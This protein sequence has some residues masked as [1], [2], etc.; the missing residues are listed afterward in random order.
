MPGLDKSDTRQAAVRAAL[1]SCQAE[2]GLFRPITLDDVIEFKP[3]RLKG[4]FLREGWS[5]VE[6]DGVW[7]LGKRATLDI[8]CPQ[9]VGVEVVVAIAFRAFVTAE[10]SQ[11]V[12]ISAGGQRLRV[13]QISAGDHR[14]HV[15]YQSAPVRNGRVSLELCLPRACSPQS[16]FVGDD[17]RELAIK[18]ISLQALASSNDCVVEAVPDVVYHGASVFSSAPVQVSHALE[19]PLPEAHEGMYRREDDRDAVD[20]DLSEAVGSGFGALGF[21][22]EEAGGR[23]TRSHDARLV[24]PLDGLASSSGKLDVYFS[25]RPYAP[26]ARGQSIIISVMNRSARYKFSQGDG[27]RYLVCL[28]GVKRAGSETLKILVRTETLTSPHSLA[29]EGDPRM[30]GVQVSRVRVQSARHGLPSWSR[31]HKLAR[32]RPSIM[33]SVRAKW[34]R[35]LYRSSDKIGDTVSSIIEHFDR[36]L[37]D[38]SG[39]IEQLGE[40]SSLTRQELSASI[41][42][43]R[44][45][46]LHLHEDLYSRVNADVSV[47]IKDAT[48]IQ[49]DVRTLHELVGVIDARQQSARLALESLSDEVRELSAYASIDLQRVMISAVSKLFEEAKSINSQALEASSDKIIKDLSGYGKQA[50]STLLSESHLKQEA[51]LNSLRDNI[52]AGFSDHSRSAV[53]HLFDESQVRN[54]EALKGVLERIL[55]EVPAHTSRSV[56]ALLEDARGRQNESLKDLSEEIQKAIALHGERQVQR[57]DLAQAVAG[58]LRAELDDIQ[59]YEAQIQALVEGL[60]SK[61]DTAVR[62]HSIRYNEDT[63]AIR[64]DY[65]YVLVPSNDLPLILHILFTPSHGYEWGTSQVMKTVV[66]EGMNVADVGA[67][68]GMHTLLLA[69]LVGEDGKVHAVEP[70]A[71]LAA[72]LRLAMALNGFYR[73]ASVINIAAGDAAG[74]ALLNRGLTSSHSSF[75]PLD[76]ALR[77]GSE[78]VEIATLDDAI[79]ERLD[80]LKI[81]A[82]GYELNILQGA[83]RH[84]SNPDIVVVA[85]FANSHV[86]RAGGKS[87]AWF[88]AMHQRG[89]SCFLIAAEPTENVLSPLADVAFFEDGNYLMVRRGSRHWSS[90]ISLSSAALQ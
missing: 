80:F 78:M 12:E 16:L 58:Q 77:A 42:E 81:D 9:G 38:L 19:R 49:G 37:L 70:L 39:R 73:R 61:V 48:K 66:A 47:A 21:W 30:I 82:E 71:D 34:D 90:L 45:N 20:L 87:E 56:S 22:A 41:D 44:K 29:G 75:F 23:W 79:P 54:E 51:S 26:L 35:G 33:H 43:V 1:T 18:L 88:A 27:N 5:D 46:S 65:G 69:R 55:V 4:I 84:L 72:N 10:H 60:H 64:T 24:V 68:V 32:V 8:L 31:H 52:M 62:R 67:N 28:P 83:S 50:I 13:V 74:Q 6:P 11:Q 3:G 25:L 2:R 76:D 15:I 89:F 40:D 14:L 36:R 59:V 85:E 86:G 57:D 7:S 17:S 53:S 63:E